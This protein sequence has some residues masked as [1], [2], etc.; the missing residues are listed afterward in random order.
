MACDTLTHEKR[1]TYDD[2]AQFSIMADPVFS[3]VQTSTYQR[4]QL[5]RGSRWISPIYSRALGR[6]FQRFRK[7]SHEPVVCHGQWDDL[8][9][10]RPCIKAPPPFRSQ[11]LKSNLQPGA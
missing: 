10:L 3:P 2:Y 11:G 5:P 6:F 8:H 7:R 4:E 1:L 9:V